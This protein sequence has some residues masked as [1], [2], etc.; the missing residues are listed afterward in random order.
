MQGTD[1]DPEAEAFL[2]QHDAAQ[3]GK[4]PAAAAAS[5]DA[6]GDGA[7]AGA[8][9]HPYLEQYRANAAKHAVSTTALSAAGRPVLRGGQ[10]HGQRPR[11]INSALRVGSAPQGAPRNRGAAVKH[12]LVAKAAAARARAA[13]AAAEAQG[14]GASTSTA[15]RR[16]RFASKDKA[17]RGHDHLASVPAKQ[18]K[19]GLRKRPQVKRLA[20]PKTP[21]QVEEEVRA[22][23]ATTAWD[24][25]ERMG[26][27]IVEL[28][29]GLS[30]VLTV[31]GAM[32]MVLYVS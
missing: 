25:T 4:R 29:I 26:S 1:A 27:E 20:K 11:V 16:V 2:A 24:M 12:P 3:A 31:F 7:P 17:Q 22:S 18:Q 32:V 23:L 21:E 6:R 19:S 28:A 15:R 5:Q 30:A 14:E 8:V 9:R 13:A 10:G